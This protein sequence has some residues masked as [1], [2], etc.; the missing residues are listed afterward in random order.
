[1]GNMERKSS[2]RLLPAYLITGKDELKRETALKRLHARVAQMGDLEFN[3][4]RF[5]GERDSADDILAACNTL[6]FASEM[7][8]V[9]VDAVDRL[10]KADQEKLV[11]YLASPST[12]T[13]LALVAATLTKN[14]RLYKA[15]AKLGNAVVDCA[16]VKKRDLPALVRGMAVTHGIVLT[17]SAAWAL[18][19]LVGD[20]TVALDAQLQKISLAHRGE[21]P[22][23][24]SEVTSLVSPTAEVK[25]WEF[26][27]AFSARN[28][29]KCQML[30]QRMGPQSEYALIGS[31]VTR[32][33]ELIAAQC[34]ASRGQ[35]GQLASVLKMPDWRVRN[36]VQWARAFTAEELR[37]ALVSARDAEWAMKSGA[38]SRAAFLDWYLGAITRR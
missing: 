20:N 29:K 31:C 13:V 5:S 10:R 33:R 4:D 15:V 14:T 22:V 1:M 11:D 9:Q 25:P 21:D 36:H 2:Q 19:D 28:V 35:A 8:L 3:F 34:L 24:D 18:L 23:N 30:L 17:E 16:P 26:V 27:D 6:P 38:D 32:I 12:S 7:R 37:C